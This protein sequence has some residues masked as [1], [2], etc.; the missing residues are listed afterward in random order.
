MDGH[1]PARP[2]VDRPHRGPNLWP[3]RP[4]RDPG[5]VPKV[6]AVTDATPRAVLRTR[7]LTKEFRGFRAVDDVDLDVAAGTVHALVGPN[8]AGK[9]T[10]FNLLTGFLSPTRGHDRARRAGRHRPAARSGSRSVGVARSF[11]ITSL[12]DAADRSPS[13]S[14][15]RCRAATG[16]GWR[17]WRSDKQ[18]RRY[19]D[20][21]R[22]AARRRSASPSRREQ[23]AGSLAVRAEARA[24]AG[25][26]PRAATR[27]CCCSTS[28]PPGMGVE[29]VDRTVELIRRVARG[30]HGRAGRAQHERRRR[31]GRPGHRAAV[32][33]GPRR[34][35]ATTRCA[36]D[37]RVITAY[38]GEADACALTGL[39]RLVRRGP[40]AARGLPRRRR[41]A[42]SS[43]S[44]AA[45]APARPRCCAAV[46]GL[47]RQMTGHGSSST[48][49]DIAGLPAAPAGPARPRLGARRPRHLR[50]AHRRGEPHAA[51]GGRAGRVVAG[52]GLRGVPGAARA[53]AP[54][55]APSS[56]AASSR[57]SPR[58]GAADG[59]PAA[60]RAT[61]RPRGSSPLLVQQI[62]EILRAGQAARR[63]PC[64]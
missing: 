31:P 58:P 14:S 3:R 2:C 33:P 18:L 27:G 11:Q 1:P 61:S 16:L 19:R 24:G 45:T 21:D 15:W 49:R 26:R 42:R 20:R 47:H 55:A 51:A 28:R 32:R 60:A 30:P 25:A 57:C 10:L 40:G 39:S 17:F 44:S 9:T 59:R 6:V 53:P 22:R 48:A 64:C 43:P 46:M 8:G 12:F 4:Y 7:G 63:R 5:P 13:T 52:P 29:D 62:G 41:A 37:P 54:A 56:P 36:R 35:P 50:H 34:G 23:P 38:L